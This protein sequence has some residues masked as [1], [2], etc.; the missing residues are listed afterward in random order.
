MSGPL[1]NKGPFYSGTIH[2]S[3]QKIHNSYVRTD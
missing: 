1:K 2:T 3:T